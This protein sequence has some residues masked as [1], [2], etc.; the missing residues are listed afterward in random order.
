MP[1]GRTL[2]ALVAS[3][4][5]LT[6]ASGAIAAPANAPDQF[7]L[8]QSGESG[9]VCQAVRNADDPAAQMRGARAWDVRCRGWDGALGHLYAYSYQGAPHI[10]AGGAWATNLAQHADCDPSV[11]A[12]VKGWGDAK[13][14]QCKAFSAKI[15]YVA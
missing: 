10:A 14:A 7:P 13:R 6:I 9:A 11:V 8:G 3:M 15:P 2:L 4:G 1:V 12:E 5:L